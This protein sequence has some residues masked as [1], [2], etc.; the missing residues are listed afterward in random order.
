[1]T[2][3]VNEE[4]N[5]ITLN[6]RRMWWFLYRNDEIKDIIYSYCFGDRDYQLE[7]KSIHTVGRV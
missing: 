2:E 3:I 4:Q 5:Q 6:R 7:T 1:M